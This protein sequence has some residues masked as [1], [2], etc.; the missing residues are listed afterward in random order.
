VTFDVG[1]T[2]AADDRAADIQL[3]VQ[4]GTFSIVDLDFANSTIRPNPGQPA[5]DAA[6]VSVTTNISCVSAPYP[7][8]YHYDATT[9]TCV[10]DPNPALSSASTVSMNLFVSVVAMGLLLL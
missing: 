1:S 2:A 8:G 9:N 3:D 6:S 5:Y 4:N 7:A 10:Q